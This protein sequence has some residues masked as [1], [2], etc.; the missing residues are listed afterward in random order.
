MITDFLYVCQSFS[1]LT[2]LLILDKYKNISCSGWDVF[3]IFWRYSWEVG[4]IFPNIMNFCMS[5]SMLVGSLPQWKK[6]NIRISQVLSGFLYLSVCLFVCLSRCLCVWMSW[7][8]FRC[9]DVWKCGYQDVSPSVWL[10]MDIRMSVYLSFLWVSIFLS[11]CVIYVWILVCPSGLSL[12]LD[13]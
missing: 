5:V 4:T 9:L 13:I 12:C 7:H 1:P 11:G 2:F 3:L 10:S 8:S 6:T